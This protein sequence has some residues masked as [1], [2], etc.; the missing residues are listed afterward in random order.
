MAVAT[1]TQL[2]DEITDFLIA[3]PTPEAIINYRVSEIFDQRAQELLEINRTRGLSSEERTEMDEFM[4][5]E[6]IM[7][8]MKIKARRQLLQK[9]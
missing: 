5:L 8:M 2:V 6:H 3:H 4:Q 1:P 9:T 7:T